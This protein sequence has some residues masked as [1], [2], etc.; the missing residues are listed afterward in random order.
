MPSK[1]GID[2]IK[3][4]S[5]NKS[6]II[7]ST[8]L[9]S[10]ALKAFDLGAQDYLLKPY[11]FPRFKVAIQK[12]LR[13]LR[14]NSIFLN[15]DLS[16]VNFSSKYVKHRIHHS[17]IQFI[18]AN[19][20]KSILHCL[21]KDYEVNELLSRLLDRLPKSTFIRIHK[22]YAV[23]KYLIS[24]IFSSIEGNSVIKLSNEDETILP[25]GKKFKSE[26]KSFLTNQ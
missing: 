2:I 11:S 6:V 12:S 5:L 17:E 23:N 25:V 21:E 20:Y 10:F 24:S 7:F 1:N 15:D 9:D 18:S 8:A 22:S 13:I 3:N 26:I 19:N 4:K 14:K 16:Y